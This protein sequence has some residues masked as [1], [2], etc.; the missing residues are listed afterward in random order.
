MIISANTKYCIY[1]IAFWF[2]RVNSL[3]LSVYLSSQ[4]PILSTNFLDCLIRKVYS[5]H[6]FTA[7]ISLP[8]QENA[9]NASLYQTCIPCEAHF[10]RNF[11]LMLAICA[12]LLNK[13]ASF[14]KIIPLCTN[15][16]MN[17]G[18]QSVYP[19]SRVSL[20]DT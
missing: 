13:F 8:N 3:S 14:L 7:E 20:S 12:R 17:E 1:H 19:S 2:S 18:L 15:T 10:V 6:I 5:N 16:N 4:Y 11:N 9:Q